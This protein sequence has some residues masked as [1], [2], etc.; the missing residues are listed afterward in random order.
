MDR[1]VCQDN[2]FL[3]GSTCV[4]IGA[5]NGASNWCR[6]TNTTCIYAEEGYIL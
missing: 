6:I 4:A 2:Y 3:I 5:S 1:G